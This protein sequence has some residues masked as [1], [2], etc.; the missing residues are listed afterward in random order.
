MVHFSGEWRI[1]NTESPIRRCYTACWRG[2]R[3]LHRAPRD[4]FRRHELASW[5]RSCQ[6]CS[7]RSQCFGWKGKSGPR[8]TS[9]GRPHSQT[10]CRDSLEVGA[11]GKCIV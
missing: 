11:T 5:Y 3:T 4:R 6:D 1:C 9:V 2:K 7:R 8:P 10:D